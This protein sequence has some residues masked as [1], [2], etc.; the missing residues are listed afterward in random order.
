M[1]YPAEVYAAEILL[2]SFMPKVK[3]FNKYLFFIK[4]N[5]LPILYRL[6]LITKRY[7]NEVYNKNIKICCF[8]YFY[9]FELLTIINKFF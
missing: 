3:K 6:A 5:L 7:K 9:L 2:F 8:F 1:A 4:K